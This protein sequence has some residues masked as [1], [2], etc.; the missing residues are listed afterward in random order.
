MRG[1]GFVVAMEAMITHALYERPTQRVARRREWVIVS[2]WGA[3][4]E[5]L[6][7]AL[8]GIEPMADSRV[9]EG[10]QPMTTFLGLRLPG[11]I[12]ARDSC[13][14]MVRHRPADVRVG[15]V[16]APTDGCARLSRVKGSLSLLAAG[17]YAHSRGEHAGHDVIRDVP[18]PPPHS[19]DAAAWQIRGTRRPWVGEFYP[20]T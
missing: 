18:D 5:F 16:Y 15:G 4:N 9:P 20:S 11:L 13:Y 1:T 8:T 6:S 3:D 14:L 12:A 2:R 19:P 7:I 10:L 17:R